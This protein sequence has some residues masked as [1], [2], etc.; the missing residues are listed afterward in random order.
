MKILFAASEAVP[1]VK[2]GGLGDV[3]GSLPPSLV[4]E[5][6]EV[7][8]VLPLYDAVSQEVRER[9]TFVTSVYVPVAWRSQYCGIFKLQENGVTWYFID[10]E[11]YFRRGTLYGAYDDGE[12]FSFF[13]RAVLTLIGT[14]GEKP[15]IIH[16]HDWQTALVPVYLRTVYAL[17]PAYAGI[18]TVFTIHNIEYQG[19][20][21]RD[22]ME[23]VLG[24]PYDLYDN[25][26]MRQDGDVNLL[27][28]A[29][30]FAD[31]VT[32]VSPTY[33]EEI[34]TSAYGH[35]LESVLNREAHKLSGI[36]NGIDMSISP[37]NDT[38]IFKNY[39]DRSLKN[40]KEN[41]DAVRE[42]V[43]LPVR[44][45][46]PLIAMV[47]RLVKHKGMD[48]VCEVLDRLLDMDVQVVVLGSGDWQ[49]EQFLRDKAW[50]YPT[51]L[52]V[53]IGFNADLAQKF[54]AGA[55]IFLMPSQSEPCGLAQM[56]AMH[57]G[58]IPVVRETG[59][60]RDTVIPYNK[61]TNQGLG[62]SFSQYDSNDMFNILCNAIALWNDDRT[63]WEKMMRRGMKYDF[64]WN[65][66]AEKYK[67]L[68]SEL[69]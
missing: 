49:Y 32:T 42:F 15:D 3:I 54:Y 64:S 25:G 41:K 59:G 50:Q 57:Y 63:S 35:G 23:N 17:D 29:I 36:I 52:A 45:D 19:R 2:S 61:Y 13:S 8:V 21:G 28:S 53:N 65:S 66:S 69:I 1:Y 20:F 31:K 60:L 27:K 26:A 10:N 18:K 56:I 34:K 24:L 33:A 58:T 38:R 67:E 43:N 14:L 55:D 68:Y 40:K 48:L 7:S 6:C 46:V 22:I 16:C 51:K 4:S 62:F 47:T 9:L 39:T 44:D 11:Y 37:K 12:R 5:D 30:I